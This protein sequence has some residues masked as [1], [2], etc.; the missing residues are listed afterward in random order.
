MQRFTKPLFFVLLLGLSLNSFA[1]KF[2]KSAAQND[3]SIWVDL[4]E[5]PDAN[6]HEAKQAFDIYWSQRDLT[7]KEVTK[8]K[9]YKVFLRWNE[10][11]QP[12]VFP[13]G[14]KFDN[15]LAAKE[16]AKFKKENPNKLK[17]AT[18]AWTF[19]GPT[20][21]TGTVANGSYQSPGGA[22][23]INCIAVDPSNSNTI[24]AGSPAGGLW[25]ST[26]GGTNWYT[27]TDNFTVMG[28]SSIVFNPTTPTTMYIATGDGD[29]GDTWSSGVLKST[30]GGTTWSNTAVAPTVDLKWKIRKIAINPSNPN[31]LYVATN[32]GLLKTTDGFATYTTVF[33]DNCYDV[34]LKPGTPT[35]VY[36]V[37]VTSAATKFYVST[38]GNTFALSGTGLPTTLVQRVSIAVSAAA[39]NN[40]WALAGRNSDQGFHGFFTSTNS[41]TSFVTTFNS[42]TSN[43]NLLGWNPTFNDVGGQAFYDLSLAVNPGNANEIFIGGVNLQK[44][45][46]GGTSWT[47]NGY[48][49]QGSTQ[50]YVHADHHAIEYLNSTTILNGND[51]GVFKTSNNGTT[52]I[53]ISNNLGIAQT[54]AFGISQLNPNLIMTGMQDNGT[55]KW[56][57]TTW[58][59]VYGGDGCEAICDP[60][61]QNIVY[62]SYVYGDLKRSTNGGTSWSTIGPN[63]T[64]ANAWI[65]PFAL[66]PTTN[67]TIYTGFTNMWR[68]TNSG[69]SF[70]KLGTVPGSGEII[71][72][73]V[74]PSAPSNIYVIKEYWNGSAYV[75]T[76]AKT[77][78]DG[79]AWT[80]LSSKLPVTLA[81]PTKVEVSPTDDNK[82]WITFSSYSAGNKVYYTADG[83][84]TFTNI[85]SNLP[86][87][88][89]NCVTYQKN[90]NDGVYIGTDVGVYYKD[91]SMTNWVLFNTG[92]PNV[93]VKE[94]EIYYD[95]TTPA[96]SKLRAA[97][98]GRSVWESD[99]YGGSIVVSAP[100]VTTTAIS[101]IA[102]TTAVTGGNVTADGGA[103][104]TARGVCYSTTTTP[105]TANSIVDGGTGTGTFTSNL[106]GLTAGTTY[107]VRAYATNS[108]GTSY[109]TQVS[110]TTTNVVI[111][112]PTATTNA[113]SSLANASA[114]LNGS[115]NANN[116]STTVTFEYGLTT[117]YG[118][119][120]N[121]TPATVT[122]STATSVS[123]AISGLTASTLYHYRVKAVNSAGTTYGA[124]ASFTTTSAPVSYCTVK[125]TSVK[126]EWIDY[127][128][129]N[130]MARTSVADAGYI[131][132]SANTASLKPGSTYTITFSA[133]FKRTIYTEYWRIWID[134]NQNGT[135]ETTE[136][137]VT[138]T[139]TTAANYT[140]SFTVPSGAAI[141]STR[142][143]VLMSDI[144]GT[145]SACGTFAYGEVEDYPITVSTTAPIANPSAEG[146]KRLTDFEVENVI[147][148][149]NPAKDHIDITLNYSGENQQITLMS[150]KGATIKKMNATS[151]LTTLDVSGLAP[152]VYILQIDNGEKQYTKKFVKD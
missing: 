124:D 15:T 95:N 131:Y 118:S 27:N 23:R 122:G 30:D 77:A 21:V 53:D 82:A 25:K 138:G 10:F 52:W 42:T 65:T 126:L 18:G 45:T 49:L 85:S 136:Q 135:F 16:Y 67:T 104:V 33:T 87:I 121:A 60:T 74:A 81:A 43:H 145:T 117:A 139:S 68:S 128:A 50:Q 28:I 4:M 64:E 47:C 79:T 56:D 97:T 96:N 112:A 83:G 148:Y 39:P 105:T 9:G 150:A 44:S 92:L 31:I 147:V 101:S 125:G 130:G 114:T 3:A 26:D 54:A 8:G 1:Q 12:R 123:A 146:S 115:V 7:K 17:S 71:A 61:N 151:N 94:L 119:T 132:A 19:L 113:A 78:N 106:S 111:T 29:A 109:G 107:Y 70:T 32:K 37:G 143:R 110:F 13:N 120:V 80:D 149:P 38:D 134:F 100:T 62:A 2:D 93:I 24:F 140:A 40:V 72:F 116:G 90:T 84:L 76:V 102:N 137:I 66:H 63:T 99:L 141:G 152:G 58:K 41:G 142:M 103:A 35:T 69:T 91:A 75:Y 46:N 55:N 22:G 88:P 36:A 108:I 5:D 14:S 11:M 127:V 51:G 133:G 59:I 6:V 57:G 89:V 73:Q 98:Y 34:E 48:W 20:K 144:S 86:N 129:L